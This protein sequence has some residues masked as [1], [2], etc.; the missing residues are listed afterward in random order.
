[1]PVRDFW[2]FREVV[3]VES[4]TV[5]WCCTECATER[6]FKRRA[7]ECLLGRDST[8]NC[9]A[10][11]GTRLEVQFAPTE[12]SWAGRSENRTAEGFLAPA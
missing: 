8:C 12:Y 1:M 2:L 6:L 10:N 9:L 5:T 4:W 11:K 3:R 7:E